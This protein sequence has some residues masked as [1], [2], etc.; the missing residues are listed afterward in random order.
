MFYYIDGTV[1]IIEKDLAVIDV[2]GIGF[3]VFASLTTISRLE[4][5]KKARL[6]T[7]P[8]I[9]EDAFDLYGF[10][11]IGEKRCFELLTS[12][13][14]VGPR[15]AISILSVAPPDVFTM[16]VITENDKML[17]AAPGVGKRIA[18]RIILELKDK[19]A[20]ESLTIPA[21]AASAAFAP[22]IQAGDK[23]LSEAMAALTVLGY[24]QQE[25]TASLQGVDLTGMGTEDIIRYVLKGSLK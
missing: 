5:G 7:H 18:Q 8:V 22:V 14:G 10:Y 11:D 15:V 1:E 17:T 2:G 24:S 25:I 20:K 21:S 9:R 12:V 6:Y 16:A 19:M 23:T 3:Q 13:S 4:I